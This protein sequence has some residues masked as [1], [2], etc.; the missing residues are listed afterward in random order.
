MVEAMWLVI[1]LVAP[2]IGFERHAGHVLSH[3]P[4]RSQLSSK[5]RVL[6]RPASEWL[7]GEEVP[8]NVLRPRE[9]SSPGHNA[10]VACSMADGSRAPKDAWDLLPQRWLIPSVVAVAFV[11]FSFYLGWFITSMFAPQDAN[12]LAIDIPIVTVATSFA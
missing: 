12:L 10:R 5:A 6:P 8:F 7:P 4:M 11:S 2:V 3:G 1:L 9:G